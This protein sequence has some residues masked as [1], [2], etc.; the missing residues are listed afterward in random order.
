ITRNKKPVAL[1]KIV[2]ITQFV[3][4]RRILQIDSHHDGTRD[5]LPAKAT[6]KSLA[7][8]VIMCDQNQ[9]SLETGLAQSAKAFIHQALPQSACLV[10]RIN[11]KVINISASSILTAQR[12]ADNQGSVGRY[13][14]ESWVT[15]EKIGHTFLVITLGNFKTFDS[16]PERKGRVVII[17]GKFSRLDVVGHRR[18]ATRSW[19]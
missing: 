3:S 19:Q 13:S 6:P 16:L 5:F 15:R 14:A 9:R 1:R 7:G 4:D 11:C 18:S 12:D 10:S 8:F 17:T 2:R